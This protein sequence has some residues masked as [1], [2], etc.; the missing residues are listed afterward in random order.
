MKAIFSAQDRGLD[1]ISSTKQDEIDRIFKRISLVQAQLSL[2]DLGDEQCHDGYASWY[3]NDA[4]LMENCRAGTSHN[5]DSI[6]SKLANL[7]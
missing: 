7:C 3:R 4:A 1:N 6:T 5:H 2:V